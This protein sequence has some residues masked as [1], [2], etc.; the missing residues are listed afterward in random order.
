MFNSRVLRSI[1]LFVCASL[2]QCAVSALAQ[3][4]DNLTTQ[5]G[6][7]RITKA[8]NLKG[9][10]DFS[11][12][13][14]TGPQTLVTVPYPRSKSELVLH[15][16]DIV[17]K[18]EGGDQ[19]AHATL[20]GNVRYTMTQKAENGVVRIV[21][22]TAQRTVFNHKSQRIEMDGSVRV[23]LTDPE[24][25]ALPG[26]IRAGRAVVEM[27]KSP[28]LYT[29][30]GNPAANDLTFT[31]KEDAPKEG[32]KPKVNGIGA[33]HVSGYDRGAFQVGQVAHFEGDGTTVEMKVKNDLAHAEI[34]ASSF[35]ATFTGKGAAS[36]TANTAK[37][38]PTENHSNLKTAKADGSARYHIVRPVGD[39]NAPQNDDINGHCDTIEY[40]ADAK[41][42]T[43]IGDV[44]AD[45][46]APGKL[47]GPAKIRVDRLINH[48]GK[49]ASYEMKG[50]AKTSLIRFTPVPPPPPPAPKPGE[51]PK[52]KPLALGVVTVSRFDYGM[53]Q[54]GKSLNLTVAQGK[55]LFQTNDA[56]TQT[57][58]QFLARDIASATDP[59]TGVT[60]AKATGEV[61]FRVTQLIPT[62]KIAQI[63]AGTAPEI[64]YV[65]GADIRSLTMPGPF[66]ATVADPTRLVQPGNLTGAAG[67][68]LILTL[69]DGTYDYELQSDNETAQ[70]NLVPIPREK[71]PDTKTAP[72]KKP[73]ATEKTKPT[74]RAGY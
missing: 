68:K 48:I 22:G 34:R 9:K 12:V 4:A 53:Y 70:V 24:R 65:G 6:D 72:T 61:E 49:P 74:R 44:D 30:T 57:N 17:T 1:L 51:K 52:K 27:D 66:H 7:I 64:V 47:I 5:Y 45:I 73:A 28:Y 36:K 55:I 32:E 41:K 19:F 26:T 43:L 16:D 38:D 8:R 15:A 10:G 20:T 62:T 31:P 25:L 54:P 50:A 46:L 71:K 11:G 39:P 23:N 42:F 33:V 14:I 59:D 2:P 56:E 67:D 13:Q 58:S 18:S 3:K 40:D 60:T 37:P 35:D 69:T 21:T 29:L 63:V